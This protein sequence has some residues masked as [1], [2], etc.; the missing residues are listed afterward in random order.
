MTG[1]VNLQ[2]SLHIFSCT[3]ASIDNIWVQWCVKTYIIIWWLSR[4]YLAIILVSFVFMSSPQ[5]SRHT[6]LILSKVGCPRNGWS[7]VHPKKINDFLDLENFLVNLWSGGGGD[8]FRCMFWP[9]PPTK[10]AKQWKKI[11]S[12]WFIHFMKY[13]TS[14]FWTQSVVQNKSVCCVFNKQGF[15]LRWCIM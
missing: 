1:S 15:V 12:G 13:I 7:D 9:P 6:L 11:F 10:S 5:I 8:W 14:K 2:N 3:K 4:Y